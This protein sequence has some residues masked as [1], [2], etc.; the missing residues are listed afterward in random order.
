MKAHDNKIFYWMGLNNV[1]I[2][3]FY[4]V[5]FFLFVEEIRS[6]VNRIKCQQIPRFIF[7]NQ[8]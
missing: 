3:K 7:K 6:N 1:K 2:L 5:L 4:A 8:G